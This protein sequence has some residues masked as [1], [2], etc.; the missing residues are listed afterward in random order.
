MRKIRRPGLLAARLEELEARLAPASFAVDAH[1]RVSRLDNLADVA[2]R[3]VFFESAVA[4]YQVLQQ[5][6]TSGTDAVLLDQGGDGLREMAAFLTGR[7]DVTSIGIVAH[8]APGMI[9]LGTANLTV[10]SLNNYAPELEVIGSALGAGGELDLWSCNVA[11]GPGGVSLVEGLT[12]ATAAGVAASQNPIGAA[13]LGGDWQLDVKVGGA[14]GEVPFTAASR[15]AFPGLLDNPLGAWN[16]AASLAAARDFQTATL[17][18][19]GKVLVAGGSSSTGT[20]ASA[21]L[22]DPATNT[23]SSAGSMASAR[24]R[25]TATLLANGKVL[26]VGGT[27]GTFALASVEIYDPATNSW[28][29]AAPMA[30]PREE[31][32]ATLLSNGQVLVAG[33]VNAGAYLNRVELYNPATDS[34]SILASMSTPRAFQTATLLSNGKVLVTGG[35]EDNNALASA[36]LYDPANN[37]WTSAGT[38]ANARQNQTATLLGNGKVLVAGGA[39][40]SAE[41]YDPVSNS[42]SDAGLMAAPR[43]R[44]TAT[45]LATGKVLVAG[46]G[47]FEVSADLYDPASNSW[48]SAGSMATGRDAQTA[49]LLGNGKVLIA[50]G[51]NSSSNAALA[52]TEVYDPAGADAQQS[53][54]TAQP[55]S[56]PLGN[57]TTITLTARDAA[58]NQET[59]GGMSFTLALGGGAGGGIFSNLTDNNDGTYT[60]IFTATAGGTNTI[61]A[62]LNGKTLTSTA[63]TITV[64][65]AIPTVTVADAGGVYN[66]L[67]Y[68]VTAASVTGNG[69]TL[70]SL[71]STSLS[72]AYFTGTLASGIGSPTAPTNA[73][74]YTVV[75]H[76][77]STNL[78]FAGA[79]STPVTFVVTPAPIT[80][81]ADTKAK[82]F[83]AADPDLTFQ[84]TA[85]SLAPGDAFTGTPSRAPGENVGSYPIGPGTLALG[86]NYALTFVGANFNVNQRAITVDADAKGKTY[87]A[88]DPALTFQLTAGTLA[89]G[90]AFTGTLNRALGENVGTYA[91][92]QG[93]LALN[94]NYAIAFVGSSLTINQRGVT[95]AADAKSKSYGDPDPA[96][97]FQITA[98]SLA[99]GDAFSGTLTRT[100]GEGVGSY[101]IQ[102][103]TLALS[104]NYALSY[105]GSSLTISQRA[106]TLTADAKS[107]AVGTTDPALTFQITA[108]SLLPGDAFT[109]S[110]SRMPGENVGSY[111]IQQ[112]TL[113]LNTNYALSFIGSNLTISPRAITVAADAENKIYGDQDPALTFQI[114]AGTLLPG[115]TF[116]GALSRIPG[117]NVGTYTIQQG[118]LALSG[119][120]ALSFIGANL[121]ISPRAITL[122][123]DAK[124]KIYGDADPALTFQVTAGSLVPGDVLVGSLTRAPGAN[125][126]SY[127]IEQG[128]LGLGGNY[129]VTYVGANLT[130]GQRVITVSADA[131]SKPFGAADPPLTFHV[132]A[133]SLTTGDAFAGAL[134]RAPGEGVGTYAIQLGA[135]SVNSN[136]ALTFIGANLT[137]SPASQ[138]VISNQSAT[139]VTAGSPITFTVTAEDSAGRAV[140]GYAGTVQL[141]SSDSNALVNGSQAPTTYTFVPADA[142]SHTFT[143]VFANAG[144]Q[145][146]T[147]TDAA[148]H[149]SGTTSPVAV[150]VAFSKFTVDV[151]GGNALVAGNAFLVTVQATDQAGNPVTS[152]NGPRAITVT[153]TPA[154]PLANLSLSGTLNN[155]GT[156]TLLGTLKTAGSYTLTATA[157]GFSGTSVNLTVAPAA[158]TFFKV[159]APAGRVTTGIS[160]P[161]TVTAMDSFGNVAN[162][163]TGKIHFTSSDAGAVLPNDAGLT[164]GV[165]VFNATFNTAGSQTITATDNAG[166]LPIITGTSRAITARGLV[167][168][169][170]TPTATGF[171][172]TFS[173]PIVGADAALWGGTVANPV[174]DVTLTG[175]NGNINGSLVIDPSETSATF[176]A[177]AVY[178]STFLSSTVLPNDTYH[179]RLESGTGTGAAASGFFDTLGA[180]L[181]GA[182]NGGHADYTTSFTT[183]NDGKP[184]LSIPDFARG[185]DGANTI[186]VPNDSGKGIPVTLSNA[187]AVK[188]V[189]FT[190]SYNP[191]LFTPQSGGTGDSSGASSTFTVGIPVTIDATHA[192]VTFTW[193][194]NVAQNGTVVLGDI[195]ATVPDSAANQYKSKEVL[196]LGSITT[197]GAVFT[198][199]SASGLH[200]NAYLGDVS[201]DG[202]ISA[203]DVA[204]G[205]DVAAGSPNSHIGLAAYRLVDPAIVGDIA[206]DASIDATAVSD[207]ASVTSS[208]AI[209]AIPAIPTGLTIIPGGPDPTLSLV[210]ER[211]KDEGGRMNQTND[212]SSFNLQPSISVMLDDPHPAGS[213]GM[214]EAVLALTYDPKALT[215]S[216]SDITLGSI[217][218]LGTGWHLVSV[219][220]QAAGQ[221]GIDLYSTTA[222][223]TTQAGSLVN[224]TF[225]IVPGAPISAAAVRIVNA[226]TPNGHYFSTEVAD[227]QG[228]F[229]LSPGLDHLLIE[230][231]VAT[232]TMAAPLSPDGAME[233]TLRHGQDEGTAP[234]L[235]GQSSLAGILL[236]DAEVSEGFDVVN[237]TAGVGEWSAPMIVSCALAF[238][239]KATTPVAQPLTE[240][241]TVGNVPLGSATVQQVMN[242]WTDPLADRDQDNLSPDWFAV[243]V[244]TTKLAGSSAKLAGSSAAAVVDQQAT[245]PQGVDP[246]VATDRIALMDEVFS[247]LA[248]NDDFSDF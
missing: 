24:A 223:A 81:T 98:G 195:L 202:K 78:S 151:A 136:Y 221:I 51:T 133:G 116:T 15:A 44:Q 4:D 215:V 189:S 176:K 70:A 28:S 177:S 167:V 91:I 180:G 14:R 3:V 85:G 175:S 197:N 86:G 237:N 67:P 216:A 239:V 100:S 25:G 244:P 110:L 186:K 122:T 27:N 142:G 47:N 192:T 40:T 10:A 201:G 156:A 35:T 17:L 109:G 131:V 42:W 163:Y 107:K 205:G 233:A 224:I 115:D 73:G 105:A 231:G 87:G 117:Q 152:Y 160:A 7:H 218:G 26:V 57:T 48:S 80:L 146:V 124:S 63:P 65:A 72:Y 246:S 240:V 127:A 166:Q 64:T 19:N 50:G 168:T 56:V 29:P 227:N 49:T 148:N 139:S 135:L 191:T 179:V 225:H 92:G 22:Y 95:V 104:G 23:W 62:T 238:Q 161:V 153:A 171:T 60:A 125:V 242:C 20:L 243:R 37:A 82:T 157:G 123:A 52:S 30:G 150:A 77:T 74:T 2:N 97:T 222:V 103:G 69:S 83:G 18:N 199:V 114:T 159:T 187:V 217:P 106:V 55:A 66:G 220:D 143:V 178:L 193:H 89:P 162:G 172:V 204:I 169:A 226:A 76:W 155:L 228:Q 132:T 120:Y 71:G 13:G 188:D 207:L 134:A 8:G 38:M 184:T 68:G 84:V 31:Q 181:D 96:L 43:F 11:S 208:I 46:G 154:D 54:V 59:R 203:L 21:E 90:D 5:G 245:D 45:L 185:P 165:G 58:G 164:A 147:I 232:V 211:M 39:G 190:L 53:T 1:L 93:T 41:I 209:T 170:L 230:T 200:V 61:I 113:G 118:T 137:I 174:Q 219:V 130:I 206:G 241:Y 141:T 229:V 79:D 212:P 145:T 88:P 99:A 6:L 149:F 140:P 36:E 75:A 94:S 182:D 138:F 32:A 128:T 158:A 9:A 16:N 129:A 34:W 119:N 183:A 12:A 210:Q 33:G 194:N 236:L 198:G 247:Q 144:N 173:K 214:E 112:G 248:G 235:A 111:A 102:Q 213:T 196:G 234:A 126:G 121:T 108:G 101:A